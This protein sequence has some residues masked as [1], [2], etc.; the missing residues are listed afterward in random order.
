MSYLEKQKCDDALDKNIDNAEAWHYGVKDIEKVKRELA[1]AN[2]GNFSLVKTLLNETT[3]RED[4]S[5]TISK[6]ANAVVVN[7]SLRYTLWIK[8]FDKYI[9]LIVKQKSK[10][11]SLK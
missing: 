11:K 6:Q 2:G 5:N 7:D 4:C 1:K 9:T 3:N 10:K 8:S